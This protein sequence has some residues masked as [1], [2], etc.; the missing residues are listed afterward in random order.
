ML[1]AL[2]VLPCA[3]KW[4]TGCPSNF[5]SV[6]ST[7]KVPSAAEII[8]YFNLYLSSS[9][10]LKTDSFKYGSVCANPVITDNRSKVAIKN[11]FIS[12]VV[13]IRCLY[14]FRLYIG[15]EEQASPYIMLC[16]TLLNLDVKYMKADSGT[17]ISPQ[18]FIII[19]WSA[20]AVISNP[21]MALRYKTVSSTL[22]SP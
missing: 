2:D 7:C 1:K 4:K 8:P 18:P 19:R 9:P 10:S 3:D 16:A 21:S 20:N 12:N 22:R 13:Q 11:P 14:F 17:F 6:Y 5:K 15:T